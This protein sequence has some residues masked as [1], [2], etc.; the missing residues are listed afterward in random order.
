MKKPKSMLIFNEKDFPLNAIRG[1]FF[2]GTGYEIAELKEKP[3]IGIVNSRTDI[4]PGHDP[5]VWQA[6]GMSG[7]RSS[8]F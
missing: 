6:Y 8:H 3:L 5:N 1:N 7:S 4:N 2:H